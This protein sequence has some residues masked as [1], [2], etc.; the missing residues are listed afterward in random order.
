MSDPTTTTTTSL[1]FPALQRAR[2]VCALVL[3]FIVGP[4]LLGAVL[5][6]SWDA[7][8]YAG[9]FLAA[10][11][12]RWLLGLPA[13]HRW[14]WRAS[15]HGPPQLIVN[16]APLTPE[17]AKRLSDELRRFYGSSIARKVGE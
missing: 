7:E 17:E 10:L 2:T 8:P 11:G 5:L 9:M 3:L 14:A 4:C 16:P 13:L 1:P 6:P 12:L 15:G